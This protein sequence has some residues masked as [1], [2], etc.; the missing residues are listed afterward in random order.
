MAVGHIPQAGR[1]VLY[2]NTNKANPKAP[3]WKGEFTTAEGVT[4]KISAWTRSTPKG[5][6]ISLAEDTY[7]KQNATAYPKVVNNDDSDIPF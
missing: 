1:G 5:T 6:L 2:T 3:D 4:V 7:N